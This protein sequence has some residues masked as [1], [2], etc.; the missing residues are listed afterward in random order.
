LESTECASWIIECEICPAY[1]ILKR[2]LPTRTCVEHAPQAVNLCFLD[3]AVLFEDCWYLPFVPKA[4][5]NLEQVNVQL[6]SERSI[7][8]RIDFARHLFHQAHSQERD[9]KAICALSIDWPCGR[10]KEM[11]IH[12]QMQLLNYFVFIHL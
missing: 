8:P 10:S 4:H 9:V 7:A 2:S 5:K 1:M 11:G 6:V 3:Q 12:Y